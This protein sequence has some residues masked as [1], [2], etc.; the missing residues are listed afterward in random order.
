[1]LLDPAQIPTSDMYRLLVDIV[2]PRPIAWIATLSVDGVANLAPYSASNFA[3]ATPPTHLFCPANHPDGRKKDTLRNCETT[4]EYVVNIVPYALRD[5]MNASSA[6]LPPEVSEFAH[7]GLTPAP[8]AKIRP[9]RV[10]ESPVQLECTVRQIIH[11]ADGPRASNIVIGK[12][13]ALHID[14]SVLRDGKIS[15]ELL[16]TIGRLGGT[17]YCR[18]TERFSLPRIF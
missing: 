9:P 4:G 11:L 10:A 12:I 2:T 3:G 15:A 17:D 1:M 7:A 8:S 5:A 6:A 16:D 13:V 14:D 18:T